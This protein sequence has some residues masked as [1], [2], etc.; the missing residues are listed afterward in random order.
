MHLEEYK[1]IHAN[2]QVDKEKKRP[3]YKT[4]CT[5]SNRRECTE[6]LELL[7]EGKA[8]LN[9]QLIAQ[10]LKTITT[11]VWGQ[12]GLGDSLVGG[13]LAAVWLEKLR[14]IRRGH[15]V[16]SHWGGPGEWG[17]Q[18]SSPVAGDS[19]LR[20]AQY[21]NNLCSRVPLSSQT[22]RRVWRQ[23]GLK[24][25][26]AIGIFRAGWVEEPRAGAPGYCLT[27]EVPESWVLGSSA[28]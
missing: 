2:Y 17:I 5:K 1:Y 6:Y 26:P 18:M 8:F 22:N 13:K 9:W 15:W 27:G 19:S 24:Y 3:Q 12:G 16:L 20:S 25:S 4:K 10:T 23:G 14:E 7:F 11:W 21:W 28:Q